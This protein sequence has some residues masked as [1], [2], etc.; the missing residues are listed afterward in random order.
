M[1]NEKE[2]FI[3]VQGSIYMPGNDDKRSLR[4]IY[5][6][7]EKGM[8]EET[9]ILCL[10]PA[11]MGNLNSNVYHKMRSHFADAYNMAVLQCDY[12]GIQHMGIF[13]EEL[14]KMM[15]SGEFKSSMDIIPKENWSDCNDMGA[16]QALDVI[17]MIF[18]FLR[19]IDETGL[20]FNPEKIIAYG[21]SH[22]SYLAYLINRFCPGLLKLIIDVSAYVY[23]V[24]LE[25]ERSLC[26]DVTNAKKRVT[27]KI[28]YLVMREPHMRLQK[29]FYDLSLLYNDFRNDCRIISFHGT[30]DKMISIEEKEQFIKAAGENAALVAVRPCDAD[31][32]LYKDAGHGLGV[33]LIK[34]YSFIEKMMPF[35]QGRSLLLPEFVR[36]QGECDWLELSYT[37]LYP[38]LKW[39]KSQAE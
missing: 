18:W 23:P 17:S 19:K 28:A 15:Q 22:G 2:V 25:T 12:F 7:P 38:V 5:S 24:F 32:R 30:E 13:Q 33:D 20:P 16:M 26:I 39:V 6:I 36:I 8:N 4:I 31:G 35:S 10:I 14:S 1:A 37:N 11:Y 34:L 21:S 9:G 29:E 27:Q 3:P